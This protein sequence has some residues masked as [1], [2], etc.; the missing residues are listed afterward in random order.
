MSDESIAVFTSKTFKRILHDGASH[1]WVL[2][3]NRARKCLY[4]I[5]LQIRQGPD[6]DFADVP[7]E[8]GA[9]F[10]I[11]KISDVI[12][13]PEEPG[14]NRWWICISEYAK[15]KVLNAWKG[16]RN[17]VRYTT[18]EEMGI[19]LKELTFRSVADGQRDLGITADQQIPAVAPR[20]QDDGS[21]VIP[22]SI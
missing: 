10:M 21:V 1:S 18:L 22:L 6:R 11:G 5:C 13:D 4:L 9:V 20:K 2:D 14:G 8:P 12:P 7:A 3:P 15:Y 19:N 17:P 16:W